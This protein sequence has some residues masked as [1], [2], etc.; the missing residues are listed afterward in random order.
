[1]KLSI[2]IEA[3][4]AMV[5][6]GQLPVLLSVGAEAIKGCQGA[7]GV[8]VTFSTAVFTSLAC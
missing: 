7:A 5:P 4:S 2:T 6:H 3:H 1:M 8:V